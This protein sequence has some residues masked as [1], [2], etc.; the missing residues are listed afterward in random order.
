[1]T[2]STDERRKFFGRLFNYA[3]NAITIAGVVLTTLS[4]LLILVFLIAQLW[5]GLDNPY[6]GLFAYVVLPIIFILGLIEIP[7]G[8]WRR[9]RKLIREGA[10][11]EELTDFP[12]LDF[13]DPHMRRVWTIV[14]VL[15]ALNAVILGAASFFAVEEMETVEFCGETCHTV[16]QPEFTA[17]QDSPHSRVACVDCHIGPGASIFSRYKTDEAN[18]PSYTAMLLRTGGGSLDIGRAGG[19]HWWHIYSDNKIRYISSDER[20]EEI[21]WVELT[22][23]DGSV[24]TYTRDGEEHSATEIDAEAR[25]MDCVDCHNRPTH[26]FFVPAKAVDWIIDTHSELRTLP[27]FKK[28]AIKAIE[29]EYE[30]HAAGMAAVSTALTDFYNTDYPEI[31]AEKAELVA[32]GADLAAQAYGKSVFPAMDTNWETH[33][34]HIGHDD[35]PGCM[36]CHDDEMTTADGEHTIPMDCETCH[37]FLLEDSSEYPEF[38]YA[39]ERN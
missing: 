32:R 3:N 12:R 37:I 30:S 16:M 9:R 27:Y 23:P 21:A 28:Q 24:R 4:G 31:A 6:I 15:T 34:N 18:S 22:T 5:G 13:N 19:I 1:M 11:E 8:M 35:F 7:I 26:T 33:P 36:R 17:Y 29:G 14:I 38:A 39:L 10:T 2:A 20:R 25:I